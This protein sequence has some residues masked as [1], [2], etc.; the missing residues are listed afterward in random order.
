ML[1]P[2]LALLISIVAI[3]VILRLKVHTGFAVL[4]GGL[5]LA[6][7]VLPWR[8][9]PGMM[10]DTICEY[11]TI[12]LLVIIASALTVSKLMEERGLLASLAR[13]MERLTPKLAFHLVP[14]VIGF[15]PMPA[16]ALV[17][18][19]AVRDLVRK[20]GLDAPQSTFINYWF[21]HIWE[22]SIPVYPAIIAAGVLLEVPLS[23]LLAVMFP[24]TLL[25]IACGAV[26]SYRIMKD[27]PGSKGVVSKGM[28]WSFLKAAWPIILLVI[29]ILAGVD[30]IIVYPAVLLLLIVQ[31]RPHLPQLWRSFRYGLE[32]RILLFL[33]A[34]MLFK[35]VIETAGAAEAILSVFQSIGLPVVATLTLLPL[36]IG[37]VTA[38]SVAFV[39]I[40]FPLLLP[41][42]GTGAGLHSTALLLAYGSGMVGM[43]ISP[44]HLC[45]VLSAEYF[46]ARLV[47]V[48]RYL[49][50]PALVV[51][52][53]LVLVFSIVYYII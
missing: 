12:R 29:L 42:I 30:A 31:Q 23:H 26:A 8:S 35:A 47:S 16:G 45:L 25:A 1:N 48:Y 28:G 51:L 52:A 27:L 19:T 24:A 40:A 4:A 53:V 49:I 3:L 34:V 50:G 36:I 11:Q 9:I 44:L 6:L 21:R 5:I 13:T 14:A 22:Y 38:H 32:P 18:A 20:I 39:G 46:K 43:M 37:L 33:Y 2:S 10:L 17:S 41:L 7:L 15:V